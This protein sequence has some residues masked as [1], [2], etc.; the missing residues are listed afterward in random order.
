MVMSILNAAS[1]L[2]GSHAEA[3]SEDH[4]AVLVRLVAAGAGIAATWLANAAIRHI[5]KHTTGQHA[6]K[7]ANDPALAI[8]H[9]VA[10]AALSGAVAVLAKRVATHG[11]T[12]VLHALT[13]HGHHGASAHDV[14]LADDA[15][16]AED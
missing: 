11:A 7:N 6:P 4:D 9:A 10:F 3:E 15:F 2:L 16:L 1:E 8:G 12:S 14:P 5:W 13:G